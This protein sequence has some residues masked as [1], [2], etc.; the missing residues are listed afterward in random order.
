MR[1]LLLGIALLLCVNFVFAHSPKSKDTLPPILL[2]S[3]YVYVEA[4]DGDAFD[5]AVIPDDRHAIADVQ[6]AILDWKRYIVTAKRK[7]AELII[8]V[9][10]GRIASVQPRVGVG[11]G[12]GTR[13]VSGGVSADV[14]SPNDLLEVFVLSPDG[15]R[16]G[17]IWTRSMKDGLNPPEIPLFQ[18]LK[19]AV[20]SASK[21]ATKSP[22]P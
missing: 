1:T 4:Y 10:K 8:V 19:Q 20:D 7:D 14:G 5:P 2:S 12:G 11:G 22:K 15:S 6:G 17:P 21:S 9:R 16:S 13:N 3:H 18:Q